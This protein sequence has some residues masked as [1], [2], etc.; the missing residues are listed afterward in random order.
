M[1]L[2]SLQQS[3]V[4]IKSPNSGRAGYME[5]WPNSHRRFCTFG[6][7]L[8]L[9]AFFKGEILGWKWEND[10]SQASMNKNIFPLI[11]RGTVFSRV[12]C[13]KLG[14]KDELTKYNLF[15]ACLRLTWWRL[16]VRNLDRVWLYELAGK[17]MER[18]WECTHSG[19]SKKH[20]YSHGGTMFWGGFLGVV[21]AFTRFQHLVCW[22]SGAFCEYAK[23]LGHI[24]MMQNMCI[25]GCV[26][27][28]WT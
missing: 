21:V 24:L 18:L 2:S 6:L 15:E 5:G 22:L 27:D 9:N 20:G 4:F 16:G 8:S 1:H 17:G 28:S 3:F 10:A 7:D 25:T 26:H 19:W 11:K 13:F 23:C 12:N 14:T